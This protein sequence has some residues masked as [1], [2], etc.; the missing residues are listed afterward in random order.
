MLSISC[1]AKTRFSDTS[2]STFTGVPCLLENVRTDD[3]AEFKGEAFA[4]VFRERGIRQEF[5]TADSPQFNDEAERGITVIESAG[6]AAIIQLGLH[7]SGMRISSSNSL[8]ATQ[9]YWAC[10]VLN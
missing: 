6:K 3:A 10:H 8:R 5:T 1:A 4:D 7:F 2:D 9:A